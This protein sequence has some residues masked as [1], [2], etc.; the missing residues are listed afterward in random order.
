MTAI[1]QG[2]KSKGYE[3]SFVCA[4]DYE[5][6]IKKWATFFPILSYGN[7]TEKELN[8]KWPTRKSGTKLQNLVFDNE[9]EF[10]NSMADQ[11][12]AQQHALGV[13]KMQH[14]GR[15][16]VVVNEGMFMGCLPLLFG[17]QGIKPAA[18]ISVGVIPVCLSSIDHPP[19]GQGRFPDSSPEGR[20]KNIALTKKMKEVDFASPQLKF[21]QELDALGAKDPGMFFLDAIYRKPDLFL[22]ACISDVEYKR[23][24]APSTLQYIG[25]L[26]KGSRGAGEEPERPEWWSEV[27]SPSCSKRRIFVTQGTVANE[28]HSLLVPTMNAFSSQP[29]TLVIV[30]LSQRGATFSS[31]L[32]DYKVPLNVREFGYVPYDD[33]L[34][35]CDVFVTNGGYGGFQQAVINGTPMV[36]CG[37]TEDKADVAARAEYAGV[38]INLRTATP[39]EEMLRRAV[40]EITK[41][42]KYMNRSLELKSKA[43]A[44]DPIGII[45]ERI[46]EL[47]GS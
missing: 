17:A 47:V 6:R 13:L 1:G 4:T 29:D 18:I 23:S 41:N 20:E 46:K 26:P 32:P 7:Y 14:P 35:H 33:I 40:D 30:A 21:I 34:P 38:A 15:E 43:N 37:D 11:H 45:D 36:V 22:Q 42:E 44:M 19:F 27:T 24:D 5:E 28:I 12:H 31:F 8:T 2:L 39:S 9:H 3:V 16:V 25:S 10:V